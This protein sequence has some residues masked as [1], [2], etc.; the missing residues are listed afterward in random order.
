MNRTVLIAIGVA[1]IIAG[2]LMALSPQDDQTADVTTEEPR[3]TDDA[4]DFEG[5][6]WFSLLESSYDERTL[7]SNH[8][9]RSF[10]L[11][12]EDFNAY[13]SEKD[14]TWDA[15]SKV[16]QFGE[17]PTEALDAI[18]AEGNVLL[19]EPAADSGDESQRYPFQAF[20]VGP[21]TSNQVADIMEYVQDHD[22]LV[23][24][25]SSTAPSLAIPDRI[26]RLVPDDTGQAR[27]TAAVMSDMGIR[28]VVP[29]Y[30]DNIWGTELY[31]AVSDSFGAIGGMVD[32]G[33]S[34]NPDT[35]DFSEQTGM[36]SEKI[37][38]YL[39]SGYA[40]DQLA[41]L[42]I[43]YGEIVPLLEDAGAYGNLASVVWFG[44]DSSANTSPIT[45]SPVALEFAQQVG[46]I[47]PS[48]RIPNNEKS[49]HVY[50]A[51]VE[52]TGI[53]PN[54]HVYAVYDA[55]WIY[56]LTIERGGTLQVDVLKDILPEVAS[57]YSGALGPTELNDAGDLA[58]A[59][60]ELF[61][62]HDGEWQTYG[63]YDASADEF[64]KDSSG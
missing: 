39:D 26:F 10:N 35:D 8:T 45:D 57:G 21:T 1:L 9:K 12:I 58:S 24:S 52:E 55:V 11:A 34:Y 36:L 64:T 28:A 62:I 59:D 17:N 23:I 49:M 6:V 15:V 4:V 51:L 47:S 42:A 19:D 18:Y 43:S 40:S 22:M 37:D 27:A 56:G 13:L 53:S 38:A 44:S 14:V 46:L 25:H 31:G 20:V 5:S 50:D 30:I 54:G 3:N 7:Y 61:W 29:I 32:E 33:V 63:V 2:G 41:V 60:Y 48:Y 16:V